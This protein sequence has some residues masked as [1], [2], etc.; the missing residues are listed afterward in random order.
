MY[1]KL[2][3]KLDMFGAYYYP[4]VNEEGSIYKSFFGAI[5]S[6]IV[7]ILSFSYFIYLIV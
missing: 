1:A 5:L 6:I 2:F 4:I 3:R 7:Y